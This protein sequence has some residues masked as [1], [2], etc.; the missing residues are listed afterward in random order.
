MPANG[1]YLVLITLTSLALLLILILWVKLHAF[2]SLL[3]S[4]MAMGLAAGMSPEKI[5]KSIQTGFG[6][7]LGFVAVVLGLGAMIGRFL[8]YSGGG[9]AL[10]D[11]L[12]VKFGKEHAAWAMLVASFLV[13][14]PIFFEVGFIIVVPLVWSLTRE[15][16]R[17]LLFYG[18]QAP[19]QWHYDDEAYFE[20]DR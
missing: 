12:L 2:L 5:L 10:A 3:L 19:Y 7:A 13:G 11:W 9:R 17:S 6:D 20:E 8:E 4:S 16:K 1:P 14:L 15:T 18:L